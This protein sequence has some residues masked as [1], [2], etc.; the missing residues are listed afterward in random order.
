[1]GFFDRLAHAWNAFRYG[2]NKVVDFGLGGGW[3]NNLLPSGLQVDKSFYASICNRLA[4]DAASINIRHVRVDQ[5]G[6]YV[7]TI[8]SMLN[9]RLTLQANIDQPSR[10]F[11]L[12]AYLSLIEDGVIAIMPEIGK[13]STSGDYIMEI[14]SLRVARVTE[15]YPKHVR[16]SAYNQAT[17]IREETTL[18]KSMVA[19]VQNPFYSVMNEP[20]STLKRLVHKMS[21]LDRVDDRAGSNRLDLVI[22]LPY[23]VKTPLRR[24]QADNRLKAIEDQLAKSSL[25]IAYAD[26]TERIVQLNRP[27]ENTLLPQI[28][29]LSKQVYEQLGLTD[30]IMN[31]S[32]PEEV[33]V[34]YFNRT[35]EPMVSAVVDSLKIAFLTTT[36]RT[37]G[38]TI[39]AFRDP[40]KLSPLNSITEMADTFIR[41]EILSANEIRAIIGFVPDADPQSDM[42]RNPNMPQE[43]GM[44]AES[45]EDDMTEEDF[46]EAFAE[47]DEVDAELDDLE[48]SLGLEHYASPYYDP[49]KAHEYYMK[50][51]ELIGRR[52]TS[53]LNDKGK[54]AARYVR[55][56]L[57]TERKS[58]QDRV[59]RRTQ[60]DISSVT[61]S[62]NASIQS[63]RERKKQQIENHKAA[64]EA[65]INTLRNSLEG[66]TGEEKKAQS[67]K[68]KT[69]V[70]SLREENQKV[71][72]QLN[73]EYLAFSQRARA[74]RSEEVAS[75]RSESSARRKDIKA[76]YD[77]KYI[78][79]LDRIK[80]DPSMLK[81][82][83]SRSTSSRTSVLKKKS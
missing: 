6:R 22:Q 69:E 5:N 50:H 9:K 29:Y 36:A 26:A 44:P 45:L 33:M 62:T 43:D 21:L 37:Q 49:V 15:W 77:E 63:A 53:T 57:K 55:E 67:A 11:F 18:P 64:M 66:L 39:M 78:E 28:E 8:D 56:Q 52:S 35:I 38:Q 74:E 81:Q 2:E 40:F 30:E 51:R 31:G 80:A 76:K 83:K 46:Q 42:L 32:A 17:G 70:A 41:N 4:V 79:E 54:E 58:K 68:V 10:A 82:K 65:K 19:I 20:N 60:K 16:L 59:T 3:Q 75:L 71:R 73:A 1:M 23:T 14:E 12:D 27:V 72:E 48:A 61:E 24:E 25:G 47:L 13:L 7:E 34:N